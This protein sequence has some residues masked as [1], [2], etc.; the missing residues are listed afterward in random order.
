MQ[1]KLNTTDINSLYDFWGDSIAN[2]LF[3]QTDTI[4]NLA[5]VEYS[6]CVSRYANDYI[7]F[8]TCSFV[9]YKKGKLIE[10]ATKAKIARG[11]MVKYIIENKLTQVNDLK[12]FNLLG[13]KY[14]EE[15]S[16]FDKFI[17]IKK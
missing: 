5:S 10:Q 4:I 3:A 9:E 16:T 2:E 1:A 12:S 17:F 11:T 8:I 7:K 13:Y 6:K 14:S 15:H